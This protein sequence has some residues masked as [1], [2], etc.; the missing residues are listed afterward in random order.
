[1]TEGPTLPPLKAFLLIIIGVLV[2]GILFWPSPPIQMVITSV[3]EDR[4]R[5][6]GAGCLPF[7]TVPV[8]V[9]L[10]LLLIQQ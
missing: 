10:V 2:L 8:I 7:T 3:Q 4:G 5:Y 1:M 6:S 9:L